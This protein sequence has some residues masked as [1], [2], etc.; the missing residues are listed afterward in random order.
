MIGE[1]FAV[2]ENHAP[3]QSFYFLFSARA[4]KNIIQLF[5]NFGSVDY[6]PGINVLPAR[7]GDVFR[8]KV[9]QGIDEAFRKDFL[10]FRRR[11]VPRIHGKMPRG[12]SVEI[13]RQNNRRFR[14]TSLSQV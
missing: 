3:L 4:V 9:R 7:V 6:K 10:I 5:R 13:S 14:R 2:I 1:R 11:F 12:R 8:A